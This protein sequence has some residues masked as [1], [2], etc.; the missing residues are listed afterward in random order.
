MQPLSVVTFVI[1]CRYR[2]GVPM[3]GRTSQLKQMA[4]ITKVLEIAPYAPVLRNHLQEIINS[5]TFKGS[6]RSQEFLE[7]V[8]E[9]ALNGHFDELK[10]RTVGVEL[11]GRPAS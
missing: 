11:F 5:P 2:G 6:R 1:C 7:Y 8:V 4:A 3:S 10:E 9:K